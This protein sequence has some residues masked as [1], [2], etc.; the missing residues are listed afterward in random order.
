MF[1]AGIEDGVPWLAMELLPGGTLAGL[2][3]PGGLDP[4]RAVASQPAAET[5]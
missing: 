5:D 1:D 3:A 4:E 2:V